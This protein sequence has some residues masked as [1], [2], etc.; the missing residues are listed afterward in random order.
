MIRNAAGPRLPVDRLLFAATLALLVLGL[1][2]V[3]DSSY[4]KTLD[5]PK[6]GNDAFFFVKRQAVGAIVGL[7][8]LF[9]LMRVGYWNLRRLAV[10]LML[11]GLGLL[12]TVWLPHI[13]INEN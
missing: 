8:A 13:G 3:F 11:L 2:M 4:V 7:F 6:L 1:W 5:S 9:T 10:P 12:C